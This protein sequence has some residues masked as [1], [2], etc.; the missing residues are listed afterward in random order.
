MKL[1]L[2]GIGFALSEC[3]LDETPDYNYTNNFH[4]WL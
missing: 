1:I 2:Y 4:C 3:T